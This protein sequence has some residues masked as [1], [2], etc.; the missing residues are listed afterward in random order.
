MY[1]RAAA[2]LVVQFIEINVY[3]HLPTTA[4]HSKHPA[5]RQV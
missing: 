1:T 2:E 5:V 4:T 3:A